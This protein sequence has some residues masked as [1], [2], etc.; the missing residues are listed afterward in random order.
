M[1][2]VAGSLQ[3]LWDQSNQVKEDIR[4][5]HWAL[6]LIGA[7]WTY[8]M[9]GY[10]KEYK[11]YWGGIYSPAP[12]FLSL[13]LSLPSSHKYWTDLIVGGDSAG[14]PPAGLCCFVGQGADEGTSLMMPHHGLKNSINMYIAM[15]LFLYC[16]PSTKQ[17]NKIFPPFFSHHF[18]PLPTFPV[19]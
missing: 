6:C 3:Y 13:S 5:L 4:R 8:S 16:F 14:H 19:F 11:S 2:L 9:Q 17:G 7:K 18:L 1:T 15:S 10:K 12:F